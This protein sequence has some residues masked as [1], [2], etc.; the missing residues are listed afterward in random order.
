MSVVPGAL[1]GTEEEFIP[2]LNTTLDGSD[3]YASAIG[4]E[5]VKDK[6]VQVHAKANVPT[7]LKSGEVVMGRVERIIEPIALID[8]AWQEGKGTRQVGL[9]GFSVLHASNV[10]DGYVKNIHDEIKIG[11]VVRARVEKIEKG[12]VDLTIKDR[13]L[14]VV[15]AFCTKCRARMERRGNEFYCEECDC[16]ENRKA[17]EVEEGG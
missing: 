11:D 9:P 10:K 16:N 17:A 8:L 2:G 3:I 13:D 7:K 12:D 14:G 5:E 6:V 1:L 15:V 4:D